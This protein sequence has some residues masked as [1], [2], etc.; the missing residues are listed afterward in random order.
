VYMAEAGSSV[1]SGPPR[2][3]EGRP[4]VQS[5]VLEPVDVLNSIDALRDIDPSLLHADIPC[6]DYRDAFLLLFERSGIGLAL[7][8]T[9]FR[10]RSVNSALSARCGRLPEE[11]RGR[12][13]A[14]FLHPSVR[15]HVLGRFGRLVQGAE[16]LSGDRSM[17][18][19]LHSTGVSGRLTAHPVRDDAG[20][21]KV[22]I[23]Q[24]TPAET[25]GRDRP[26]PVDGRWKLAPLTAKVLE[27]VAAG[28]P[29]VRLA[30]KLF[31]S[32]QGIEYHVGVLL[33]QFEVP[34]RTALAA[35]AYAMGVFTPGCWPPRLLPDH[36]RADPDAGERPEGAG[37]P[38]PR[39]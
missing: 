12:A 2:S 39:P 8:D 14:D 19:S 3:A 20:Q 32:R 1:K 6:R 18:T 22:L 10:V 7:L 23:V 16:T 13:F 17:E 33:R 26:S 4:P 29:T 31:L 24:F 21:V 37:R 28:D 35:K 25:G 9:A 27:G 15:R 11:M 30:A 38:D 36:I 34:N 5:D